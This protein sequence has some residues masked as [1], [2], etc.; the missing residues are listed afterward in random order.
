MDMTIVN[1]ATLKQQLSHY[2]S[3]ARQGK[4]VLITSHKRIIARILAET[5]GKGRLPVQE[6]TKNVSILEDIGGFGLPGNPI[7]DMIKERNA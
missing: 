2:L 1:T 5:E 7:K 3:L 4:D 6:P